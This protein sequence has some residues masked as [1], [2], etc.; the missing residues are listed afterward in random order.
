MSYDD[1]KLD[2]RVGVC[3]N[4]ECDD[5]KEYSDTLFCPQCHKSLAMTLPGSN[6]FERITEP[7]AKP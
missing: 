6:L 7:A 3:K 1:S 4:L 5:I 2:K